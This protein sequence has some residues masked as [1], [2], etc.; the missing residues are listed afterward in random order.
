MKYLP[1]LIVAVFLSLI[2]LSALAISSD[3]F[4]DGVAT[5]SIKI[6]KERQGRVYVGDIYKWIDKEHNIESQNARFKQIADRAFGYEVAK[7]EQGLEDVLG[8][9]RSQEFIRCV[10]SHRSVYDDNY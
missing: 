4:C 8:E 9:F 10:D 3:E 6:M 1:Q 2:S 5:E 7:T